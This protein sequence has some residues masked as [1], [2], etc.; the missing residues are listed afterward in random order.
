MV[1]A[2]GS[3]TLGPGEEADGQGGDALAAAGEGE[4]LGGLGDHLEARGV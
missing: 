3:L 2:I 1:A 4:P